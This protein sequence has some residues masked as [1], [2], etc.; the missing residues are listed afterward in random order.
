MFGKPDVLTWLRPKA[1]VISLEESHGSSVPI[2]N[3]N[4]L[5]S[6]V[7][8]PST[9]NLRELSV[10]LTRLGDEIRRYSGRDDTSG[11]SD[12]V[13]LHRP[14]EQPGQGTL[15]A[16]P[17]QCLLPSQTYSRPRRPLR[18]ARP[19]NAPLTSGTV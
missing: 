11:P 18:K 12:P 3:F 4:V 16:T 7:P 1:R 8:A 10:Q 2:N 5:N 14:E 17:P 9:P 6:P 19:P 13:N 15:E